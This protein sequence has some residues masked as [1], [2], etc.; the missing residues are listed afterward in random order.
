MK[1]CYLFI[2]YDLQIVVKVIKLFLLPSTIA[3]NKL[4]CC[5]TNYQP[6]LIG[7]NDRENFL[8]DWHLGPVANN[9]LQL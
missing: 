4:E 3:Q 9:F 6:I 8:Y 2:L 5:W 1:F 7:T